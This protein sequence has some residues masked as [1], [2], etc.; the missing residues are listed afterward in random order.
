MLNRLF[1]S[2]E[3]KLG[4]AIA[5]EDLPKMAQYLELGVRKIDYMR[6]QPADFDNGK[7]MIPMCKYEDPVRLA[8]DTGL[9]DQGLKL[10]Q[11]YGLGDG[12]A[13]RGPGLSR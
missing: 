13:P 9:N 7:T 6:M 12:P 1:A 10:L 8:K 2:R 11:Q 3:K 4:E 5:K